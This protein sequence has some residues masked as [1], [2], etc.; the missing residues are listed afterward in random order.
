[1]KRTLWMAVVYAA[2]MLAAGAARAEWVID[3]PEGGLGYN[4]GNL[5]IRPLETVQAQVKYTDERG[6]GFLATE[7]LQ[8]AGGQPWRADV[9]GGRSKR[10]AGS[11]LGGANS[12][13][14][15]WV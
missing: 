11:G 15:G 13:A 1:M 12:T 14:T 10:G 6:Y 8:Q 7:G 5:I 2:V 9:E 3:M 4:F